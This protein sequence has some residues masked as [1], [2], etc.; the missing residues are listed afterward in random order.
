MKISRLLAISLALFFL[1]RFPAFSQEAVGDRPSPTPGEAPAAEQPAAETN[2]SAEEKPARK[3]TPKAKDT[4]AKPAAKG[5]DAMSPEQF[6]AAGLDKLSPEE[7][8][9][10]DASLKGYQRK[11]ETKATEKATAQAEEK[12]KVERR[13]GFEHIESRV[14]GT[15]GR[16]TGHSII[17]LEDGTRWKQANPED[18]YRTQVTD[19]PSA[20]VT[21]G[22]FGYKIRIAGLPDMYVDP[23]RQ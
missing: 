17:T 4:N 11:V 10:L 23:V 12:I 5:I 18:V 20:V 1:A 14:D 19:H 22:A 7:L 9:N 15:L 13:K 21:R 16:L 8:K 3:S 2:A 6:K